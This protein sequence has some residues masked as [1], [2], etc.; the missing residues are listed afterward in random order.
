[1]MTTMATDYIDDDGSGV[2]GNN[3]DVID[4]GNHRV[5]VNEARTTAALWR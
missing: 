1:M 4:D 2:M 5:S 3:N